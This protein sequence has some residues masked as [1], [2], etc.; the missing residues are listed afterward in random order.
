MHR[1][2]AAPED[3]PGCGGGRRRAD[4]R[5]RGRVDA[6]ARWP[7]ALP[8][9]TARSHGGQLELF[10]R[11][12]GRSGGG[13]DRRCRCATRP[14]RRG[15]S[16]SPGPRFD[17]VRC[18]LGL[19]GYLPGPTGAATPSASRP[20]GERAASGD[21]AQGAGGRGAHA[22]GGGATLLRPACAR[23]RRA[24]V[25][26]VPIGY[27]DGVPAGP[28]RPRATSVL[29][30]GVRR[31]LAGD[32]DDGPDRGRLRRRRLGATRR[33]GRAARPPGGRDD[34]GGRLG[35]HARARSATRWSAASGRGC[36]ASW[37][38]APTATVP[39]AAALE[40]LRVTAS[41]CTLCPLA[42]GRTQVVFGVGSPDGRAAV[43]RRGT[44][45][46][47]GPGRRALRRPLGQAARPPDGGG[48]RADPG[49]V[50]HRQRR[51]V[52]AAQQPR[53]GAQRDR[54]RAGRT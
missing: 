2:G 15:P 11:P 46:R 3:L 24:V 14:T 34:H 16:P 19:Y 12:R 42:E 8:R 37:S 52:P 30:G 5:A 51:E 18:G 4:A 9:T 47:G 32:G 25:A 44:G 49:R 28:V 27:A 48:G 7:T 6:P 22:R 13:G 50:L 38:T 21:V 26:T 54:R 20:P 10:E 17:M 39:D 36:R 29:I 23:S 31:P 41:T 53:P 45:P 33:R 1:V 40:R 43:R 35:G